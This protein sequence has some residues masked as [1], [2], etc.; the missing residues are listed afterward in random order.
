LGDGNRPGIF[1]LPA[2]TIEAFSRSIKWCL[3]LGP[4]L[5]INI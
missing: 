1:I 2:E 3:P 5:W 4:Q